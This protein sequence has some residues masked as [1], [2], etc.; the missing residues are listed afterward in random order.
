MLRVQHPSGSGVNGDQYPAD[1]NGVVTV[2]EELAEQLVAWH[3]FE[4]ASIEEEPE[5]EE[6]AEIIKPRRAR[7]KAAE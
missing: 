7:T 5:D 2:P 4:Y 3:G 1:K 6:E